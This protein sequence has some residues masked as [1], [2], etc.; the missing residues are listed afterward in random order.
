M[1]VK[2]LRHPARGTQVSFLLWYSC[3]IFSI[4]PYITCLASSSKYNANFRSCHFRVFTEARKSPW[5]LPRLIWTCTTLK[6]STK[7]D[8]TCYDLS[9][10]N[11]TV[12]LAIL[13]YFSPDPDHVGYEW[14]R[15][16]QWRGVSTVYVSLLT[17]LSHVNAC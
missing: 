2:S 8:F 16:V 9:P 17:H 14:G 13:S 10:R 3:V 5:D 4:G 11:S 1:W 7:Y 6:G 15:C 12:F